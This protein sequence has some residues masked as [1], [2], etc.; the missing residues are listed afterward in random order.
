MVVEE[1]IALL[2][3]DLRGEGDLRKFQ[4]GLD[5]ATRSLGNFART[6]AVFAAAAGTAIVAGTAAMAKSVVDVGSQFE[7]MAAT[8]E[9]MEGSAAKAEES[10]KWVQQ[11]AT[12]TP[13]DLAQVS[14]AFVRM[15]AY[16]IDPTTGLLRSVGDASSAMGKDLMSGVEAVADAMTGENER[17][18][19]FGIRASVAGDQITYA[20]TQNGQEMKR[21]V[22]KDASEIQAALMGIF[23][24]KFAGSMEKASTTL[25]GILSNLGDQWTGFLKEVGDAGFYDWVK[26]QFR[27]LLDTFDQFRKDGT[28]AKVAT[29]ISD[30]L[31][32]VGEELKG[33]FSGITI[34]DITAGINGVVNAAK[35]LIEFGRNMV[36]AAKAI[37]EFVS[38]ILGLESPLAG[39]AV[40]I[41]GVA[42]LFNP[43]IAGFALLFL[44]LD[45]LAAYLDGR[46]SAIGAGIQALNDLLASLGINVDLTALGDFFKAIAKTDAGKLIAIAAGVALLAGRLFGL[47]GAL[48]VLR[49]GVLIEFA[50][51]VSKLVTAL[52]GVDSFDELLTAL[53]SLSAFDWAMLAGGFLLLLGP[54]R[55]VLGAVR[56]LIAAFG[57][58][59]GAAKVP[60]LPDQGPAG[61]AEVGGRTAR[62]KGVGFF[63]LDAEIAEAVGGW[64]WDRMAGEGSWTQEHQDNLSGA[65]GRVMDRAGEWLSN[66]T[67]P[68]ETVTPRPG[69]PSD[70]VSQ[71]HVQANGT[72]DL[73]LAAQLGPI[74]ERMRAVSGPEA[75]E[76]AME[77]ID[78]SST[79]TNITNTVNAPVTVNATTNASPAQI[80]A[81]VRDGVTSAGLNTTRRMGVVGSSGGAAP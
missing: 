34:D 62:P 74:L 2:G 16:G 33:L 24:A 38:E 28:L 78:N 58:L 47:A 48:W 73:D 31:V 60:N 15:R 40:L 13:Y 26:Q 55:Q 57:S 42:A 32:R 8:L 72:K 79:I 25:T 66:F 53:Q 61:P 41:G 70:L 71:S 76:A 5:N 80:G 23:D 59:K 68:T 37:G 10:L 63:G 18:K 14:Q 56:G 49:I 69:A 52:Q 64:L 45:D 29:A 9:V 20:W 43:W 67:K 46:S 17:L 44:F 7:N 77:T 36:V 21:T 75:T 54:I 19:E 11:F 50:K 51:A 30:S 35:G 22:N 1:L 27:G 81:S 6:A 65:G 39:L 12:T 3:F 4:S